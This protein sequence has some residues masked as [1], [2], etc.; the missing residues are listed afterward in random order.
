MS[1]SIAA[2]GLP[3][4]KKI[5]IRKCAHRYMRL[6]QFTR[7]G[8]AQLI[9]HTLSCA[10]VDPKV[11]ELAQERTGGTEKRTSFETVFTCV[12]LIA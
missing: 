5:A 1:S 9:K 7:L 8:A 2:Q 3:L 4:D 6:Q 10:R 11:V 12:S